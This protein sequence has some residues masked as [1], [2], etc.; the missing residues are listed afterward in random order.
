MHPD[1]VRSIRDQ[2]NTAGVA[3]HFKQ[4]VESAPH[5]RGPVDSQMLVFPVGL[6]T[7]LQKFGKRAARLLLDRREWNELPTIAPIKSIV[8]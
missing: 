4:W 2:C 8:A 1:W 7:P 3:F 5:D 6:D